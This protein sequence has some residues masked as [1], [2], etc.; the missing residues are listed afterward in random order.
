MTTI[1]NCDDLIVKIAEVMG[2][3]ID[4]FNEIDPK[5]F[6]LNKEDRESA[7][8]LLN[9]LEDGIGKLESAIMCLPA[10]DYKALT[11]Q[12]RSLGTEWMSER[13]C[14]GSAFRY[15]LEQ[16]E[17]KAGIDRHQYGGNYWA[18]KYRSFQALMGRVAA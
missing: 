15:I 14:R 11:I 1:P 6:D 4:L 5:H 7:E 8:H 3:Y 16:M 13:S 9:Y 18:G 17:A 12:L 10:C 2:I